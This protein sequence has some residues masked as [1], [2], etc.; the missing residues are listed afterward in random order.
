YG[1][2]DQKLKGLG[3][4]FYLPKKT[5]PRSYI[6]VS[7]LNDLD[8]GQNYYGE[9]TSDNI[10]APA[11]RKS[12]VPVKFIKNQEIRFAFFREMTPW[13]SNQITFTHKISLP[14]QNLPPADSFPTYGK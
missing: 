11:I 1:F 7:L 8:H 5:Y 10:F 6:N 12:Y 9:V 2:G 13:M 14:L 3:E 4:I